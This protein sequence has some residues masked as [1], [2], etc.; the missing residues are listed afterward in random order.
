MPTEADFAAFFATHRRHVQAYCA[1]RAPAADADEAVIETFV[2]AWR[3][4][5]DVPADARPWLYGVARRVLANGYRG[6]RRR[7]A[8]AT[9]VAGL[10]TLPPDVPEDV[11]VAAAHDTEVLAAFSRLSPEDREVLR[12]AVWEELS[13]REISVVLGCS[14]TAARQRLRRAR[15]R[16]AARVTST[17][18][19]L[20]GGGS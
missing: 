1:R 10:R 5:D 13:H 20:T 11:A 14:E 16:L 12:L 18:G 4:W 7:S 9:R 19:A 3:R 8:L 2:V 6:A 17:D 15:R